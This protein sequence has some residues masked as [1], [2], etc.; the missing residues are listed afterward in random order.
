M[1][2][3]EQDKK[4]HFLM[5]KTA[6]GTAHATA[7]KKYVR[8]PMHLSLRGLKNRGIDEKLYH[9]VIEGGWTLS[10]V[11]RNPWDHAVSYYYHAVD[12]NRF[13]KENFFTIPNF[14]TLTSREKLEKIDYTFENFI[15]KSY[16]K[17]RMQEI[18][19]KQFIEPLELG[20]PTVNLLLFNYDNIG[21]VFNYLQSDASKLKRTRYHDRKKIKPIG[22]IR[23]KKD[24]REL[25][26]SRTYDLINEN[27]KYIID[28]FNYE[29]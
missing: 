19:L 16:I 5:P 26:N 10:C 13:F 3:S 27:C 9:D 7:N 6:S 2:V 4:I 18:Q 17:H 24:Y 8:Y 14:H 20:D 22:D 15:E 11:L 23:I 29:F 25:F 12:E 21:E 1:L 28:I